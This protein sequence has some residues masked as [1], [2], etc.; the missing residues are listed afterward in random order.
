MNLLVFCVMA[1]VDE[2]DHMMVVFVL[3]ASE[4]LTVQVRKTEVPSKCNWKSWIAC[5]TTLLEV[6]L[7]KNRMI[8]VLLMNSNRDQV[9]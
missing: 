4:T 1:P 9:M 2:D 7:S 6:R 3:A 5:N 8:N